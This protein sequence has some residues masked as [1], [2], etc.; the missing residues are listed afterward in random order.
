MARFDYDRKLLSRKHRVELALVERLR[1]TV[2]GM[3]RVDAV[4]LGG[5]L[6]GWMHDV[7]KRRRLIACD[8]LSRALPHLPPHECERIARLSF[9]NLGRSMV[10]FILLPKTTPRL[11]LQLMRY[12]GYHYLEDALAQGKGAIVV[13]GHFGSWEFCGAG[14]AYRGNPTSFVV[15]KQKNLGVNALMNQARAAAGLGLIELEE[16]ARGMLRAL[17]QNQIVCLL[18]DQD[19]G[20]EGIFVPFLGRPASTT[21]GPALFAIKSGAPLVPCFT[22]RTSPIEH[23]VYITEPIYGDP[24]APRDAEEPRVMTE[25]NRRLGQY[26]LAYPEQYYWMHRRFKTKPPED[27]P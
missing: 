14:F 11:A 24:N 26:A 19:A 16:A 13:T 3:R 12:D 8:N 7:W 2:L 6:G 27:L 4:R 25:F 10:E 23:M 20:R 17:H 1:D 15:G 18:A 21:R 5:T 9:V 22:V